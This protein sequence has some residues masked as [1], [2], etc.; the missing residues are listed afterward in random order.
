MGVETLF[1]I[2]EVL[3]YNFFVEVMQHLPPGLPPQSPP[4]P[5]QQKMDELNAEN[6]ALKEQVSMLK[7]LIVRQG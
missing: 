6:T 2:C 4:N 3:K 7:D 1:V 5:L